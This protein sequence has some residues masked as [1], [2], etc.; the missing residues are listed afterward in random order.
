[1]PVCKVSDGRYLI[2][3]KIRELVQR[4]NGLY[5][6]NG[7]GFMKIEEFI[8][9]CGSTESLRIEKVMNQ[10]NASKGNEG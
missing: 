9:K 4:N 10:L 8:S 7:G 5:V 3:T 6:R 2:G 1:M